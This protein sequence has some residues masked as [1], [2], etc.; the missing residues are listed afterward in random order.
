[1]SSPLSD[2]LKNAVNKKIQDEEKKQKNRVEI[3]MENTERRVAEKI[4]EI[5]E[6]YGLNFYYDGYD[7]SMYV[8][9]GNLRHSGA[10]SPFIKEFKKNGYLGFQYGA[11][12]DESLMDHRHYFLHIVYK[13]KRDNGMSEWY[14]AYH[15]E[16]VNE[17]KILD[18][19]RA[20]KHPLGKKDVF[21]EQGPIWMNGMIGAAP[22]ALRQWKNSGAIKDIFKEELRKLIK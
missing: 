13:H 1:M 10:I 11:N 20:G 22:D 4:K 18:N 17:K 15:D 19:F 16:N 14:Y 3:A 2:A 8:R 21:L 9:T 6:V 12:F 5:I 7:P